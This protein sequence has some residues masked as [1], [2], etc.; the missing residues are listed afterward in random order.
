[1]NIKRSCDTKTY[2][3]DTEQLDFGERKDE[4]RSAFALELICTQICVVIDI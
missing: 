3:S 4:G 2:T 1:M